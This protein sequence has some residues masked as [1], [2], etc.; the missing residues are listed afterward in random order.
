MFKTPELLPLQTKRSYHQRA[1]K[2][3]QLENVL[4]TFDADA[5]EEG[6]EYC[7]LFCVNSSEGHNLYEVTV[8]ANGVNVTMEINCIV[9]KPS[10]ICPAR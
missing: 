1:G 10:I 6:D 5:G 2:L 4:S 3:H 8:Q 7:Q 9:R